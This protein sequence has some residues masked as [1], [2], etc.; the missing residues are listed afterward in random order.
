MM[1]DPNKN[2]YD[3]TSFKNYEELISFFE[4]PVIKKQIEIA[5]LNILRKSYIDLLKNFIDISINYKVKNI[6][7]NWNH[8]LGYKE[9][10]FDYKESA[11]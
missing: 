9:L 3:I 10:Y 5:Q 1:N 8:Q 6:K 2:S 11:S 7:I 4:N